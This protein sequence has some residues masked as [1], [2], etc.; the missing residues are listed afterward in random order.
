MSVMRRVRLGWYPGDKVFKVL[1]RGMQDFDTP[2]NRGVNPIAGLRR[3]DYARTNPLSTETA[4][5]YWI[6]PKST[7]FRIVT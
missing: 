7:I 2:N 5:E 3:W 4:A 6:N 1:S